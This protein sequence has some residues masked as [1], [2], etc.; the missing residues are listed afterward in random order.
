MYRII[1]DIAQ[2]EALGLKLEKKLKA[3]FTERESRKVNWPKGSSKKR[4]PAPPTGDVMF[5]PRSGIPA[6]AWS[7]RRES[8]TKYRNFLLFGEPGSSDSMNIAVQVNFPLGTFHMSNGGVFLEDERGRVWI[9][10]TGKM[11]RVT[12]LKIAPVLKGFEGQTVMA[13]GYRR[14]QEIILLTRLDGASLIRDLWAF[15]K[16][17]RNVAD[18]VHENRLAP[19]ANAIGKPSK[20]AQ[21]ALGKLHKYAKEHS[22][23]GKRK[24]VAKGTRDVTHGAIVDELSRKVGE[25]CAVK[26]S[27]FV[28]LAFT[29][30]SAIDLFEVKTSTRLQALYTSIGQLVVHGVAVEREARLPTRRYLV[31]PGMPREDV[32][33]ILREEVNANVITYRK[34]RYGYEFRGLPSAAQ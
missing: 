10:H 22:G 8:G 18:A 16:K 4:H 29:S 3:A 32:L 5:Q 12:A 15:A 33:S 11:T 1:S 28:D 9:G 2:V 27:G 17:A 21:A 31:V 14:E 30:G 13:A 25:G 19:S 24:A 6:R 23:R 20:R 26:N 34:T 7:P